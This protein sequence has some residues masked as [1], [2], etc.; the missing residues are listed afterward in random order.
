[1]LPAEHRLEHPM[2][3]PAVGRAAATRTLQRDILHIAWSLPAEIAANLLPPGIQPALFPDTPETHTA[4]LVLWTS[5]RSGARWAPLPE[6]WGDTFRHAELRVPI[7]WNDAPAHV[8]VR[9]ILSHAALAQALFPIAAPV[10]EGRF[11]IVVDGN[12]ATG[13]LD[14][15]SVSITTETPRIRLEA[16]RIDP[17]TATPDSNTHLLNSLPDIH[18]HF[19]RLGRGAATIHQVTFNPPEWQPI[20]IEG[21]FL[22]DL[23]APWDRP[24]APLAAGYCPVLNTS[25]WPRR[26][27]VSAKRSSEPAVAALETE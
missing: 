20:H 11:D 4:R 16:R 25:T 5:L 2:N 6:S 23:P 24:P 22:A 8:V 9:S 26:G 21:T 1:M 19:P 17:A 14:S 18:I 3:P 10:V 7:V 27:T 15:A 13:V 12:P